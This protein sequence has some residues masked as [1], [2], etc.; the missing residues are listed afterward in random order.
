MESLVIDGNQR[1]SKQTN[2]QTI[3]LF[4]TDLGWERLQEF[5]Q[6]ESL[7][8]DGDGGSSDHQ[9]QGPLRFDEQIVEPHFHTALGLDGPFQLDRL[10]LL[11]VNG[12]NLVVFAIVK[13]DCLD[14]VKDREQMRLKRGRDN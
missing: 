10:A 11:R 8:V 13:F 4:I 2:R 7:I 5:K 14:V 12:E 3:H 1:T 9:M 6:L